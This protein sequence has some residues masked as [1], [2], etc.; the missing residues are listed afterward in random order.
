MASQH[1]SPLR[2][3]LPPVN[4]KRFTLFGLDAESAQAWS[5]SLPLA[6]TPQAAQM[7][8]RAFSD[9][10]R[11]ELNP[12]LRFTLMEILR[13][14]LMVVVSNLAQRFLTRPL[15]LHEDARQQAELADDLLGLAATGYAAVA[16]HTIRDRDAIT[17]LNPARLVCEAIYRGLSF[18]GRD[19]LQ[20]MQLGQQIEVNLWLTL[21]QLY[22]LAERQ[23]LTNLP[24]SDALTGSGTIKRAYL[25]ALILGCSKPNQLRQSDLAGIY[26]GLQSWSEHVTLSGPDGSGMFLV[27][28]ASDAAPVYA[29]M[30]QGELR[31]DHRHV[32]TSGLLEHLNSLR[33]LCSRHGR[34]G[35]QFDENAGVPCNIID[36][37]TLS[38]GSMSQRHFSRVPAEGTIAMAVGLTSTHF[39]SAGGRTFAELLYG[40]YSS[41]TARDH[42]YPNPFL[43]DEENGDGKGEGEEPDDTGYIVVE[44]F[45]SAAWGLD[46]SE[47]ASAERRFP[48]HRVH[49]ADASPGGYGLEWPS[50]DIPELKAGDIVCLREQEDDAWAVAAVR[51]V[52]QPSG[53]RTQA[54]L[55]L[56]SPG[57]K[58]YGALI[59]LKNSEEPEPLRVLLLPEI[60]LV[61]Q[62]HT[63]ITPRAGFREQQKVTLLRE[64]E[65]FLIQLQ[66][67]IALT[68]SYAQFD[69]RYIKQLEEVLA[70]SPGSS[71]D[72]IYDS[73]WNHI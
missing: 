63:L 27:D 60:S 9:L 24:V 10:N 72:S 52:N 53:G 48:I 26:R 3:K 68:G 56:L 38:L 5:D 7:L 14:N 25:Q 59:Q 61:G 30:Y 12:E 58:P 40:D 44:E 19:I 39:H 73:V 37:L 34:P 18:C 71:V 64:G 57:A 69:F 43:R 33:E 47:K 65:E 28:L 49:M 46:Q 16:V 4:L 55:E 35:V 1:P 32:D 67:Q 20:S 2:L 41:R 45:G 54:G 8:R 17:G 66:T 6:N 13:P 51:W 23:Q 22:A 62:P 50:G 31:P 36:H 42:H 21:H 11:F 15:V 29:A 70:E